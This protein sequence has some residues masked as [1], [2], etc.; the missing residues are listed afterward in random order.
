V[1]FSFEISSEID[2]KN[3]ISD[4]NEQYQKISR[5]SLKNVMRTTQ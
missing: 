5:L 3:Y 1:T 4:S 2:Q